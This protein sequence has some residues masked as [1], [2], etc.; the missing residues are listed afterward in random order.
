MAVGDTLL[1]TLRGAIGETDVR[2]TATEPKFDG[3]PEPGH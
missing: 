1:F 3:R 2:I